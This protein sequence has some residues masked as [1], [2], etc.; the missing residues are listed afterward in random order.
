MVWWEAVIPYT[1]TGTS[2]TPSS[3]CLQSTIYNHILCLTWSHIPLLYYTTTIY[4]HPTNTLPSPS[5]CSIDWWSSTSLRNSTQLPP[6]VAYH[7]SSS[8]VPPLFCISGPLVYQPGA[9]NACEVPICLRVT[10]AKPRPPRVVA[11]SHH[12]RPTCLDY[13]ETFPSSSSHRVQ[14]VESNRDGN[15]RSHWI[16]VTLREETLTRFVVEVDDDP[17]VPP[18]HPSKS[19]MDKNSMN[20]QFTTIYRRQVRTW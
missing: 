6:Q 11:Q 17:S 7:A 4:Y 18:F 16:L 10:V 9:K 8:V 14:V 20:L 5:P 1:V 19:C 2:D 13:A 15:R 3:T 12:T